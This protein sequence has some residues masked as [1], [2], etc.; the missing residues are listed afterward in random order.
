VGSCVYC[1]TTAILQ[2]WA[3]AVCTFLQCLGQLSLLPPVG[4]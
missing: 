1:T 4:R 2:P 3:R